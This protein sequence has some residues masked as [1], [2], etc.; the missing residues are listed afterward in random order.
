MRIGRRLSCCVLSPSCATVYTAVPRAAGAAAPPHQVSWE[1][2]AARR[3]F[4]RLVYSLLFCCKA[5]EAPWARCAPM[6]L[7]PRSKEAKKYRDNA[8]TGKLSSHRS[9]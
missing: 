4:V 1:A 9:I 7:G 6:S 2:I 8:V 5:S 3:Q